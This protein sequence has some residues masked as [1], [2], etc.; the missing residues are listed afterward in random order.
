MLAMDMMRQERG[1]GTLAPRSCRRCNDQITRS[2]DHEI[3][4][5]A[6]AVSPHPDP[7]RPIS[8]STFPAHSAVACAVWL[9]P[10]PVDVSP[11][12]HALKLD[13]ACTTTETGQMYGRWAIDC[14]DVY[15]VRLVH[16]SVRP[17]SPFLF[18]VPRLLHIQLCTTLFSS[19]RVQTRVA[20]SLPNRPPGP[21]SPALPPCPA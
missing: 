2:R 19:C 16:H 4:T 6:T 1:H 12:S 5:S 15:V 14:R 9:D 7:F 18:P 11:L 13:T 20:G 10:C 17:H 3:K 8:P 21:P